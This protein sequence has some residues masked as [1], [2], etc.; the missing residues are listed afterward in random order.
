MKWVVMVFFAGG[1]LWEAARSINMRL[2][3][4]IISLTGRLGLNNTFL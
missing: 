2:G 4:D 3:P 1:L